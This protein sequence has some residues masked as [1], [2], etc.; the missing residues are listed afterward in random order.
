RRLEHCLQF[1]E[2]RQTHTIP[3]L[4]DAL[5]LVARRMPEAGSA[6]WL[7]TTMRQHFRQ[8]MEIYDRVI[9]ANPSTSESAS[10]HPPAQSANVVRV[11]EQRAPRLFEVLSKAELQKGRKPFEHF[12]EKISGETDLLGKLEASPDFAARTLDLF[13]HSP[14]FAEELIRTP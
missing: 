4:K 7:L 8:V 10:D 12:L 3:S 5:D 13:E 2:D 1:A 6:E 11:L 14:Y 9:H